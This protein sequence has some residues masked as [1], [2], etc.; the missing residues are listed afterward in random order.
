MTCAR[1]IS[2]SSLFVL[3]LGCTAATGGLGSDGAE[4]D[5][6]SETYATEDTGSAEGMESAEGTGDGDGDPATG[7]GD[8]DPTTGD[9]DGDGD[10]TTGD[11]DG[12][13]SVCGDG[14]AEADETCDGA[15]LKGEDCVTLGFTGGELNCDRACEFDTSACKTEFCGNEVID[16]GEECDGANLDGADCIELGQGPGEPSCVDCVL[17]LSTCGL[18][19]EGDPCGLLGPYCD[20]GLYCSGGQCWDGSPGDD[21]DWDWDCISG[22]CK[23]FD[24]GICE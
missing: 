9:G 7:D 17:D 8:G 12:E 20:D 15:D 5:S 22:N 24:G 14:I 10:P 2:S 18:E 1:R 16:P 11:G 13:P 21:C 3:L 19:G 23:V 4:D 6:G